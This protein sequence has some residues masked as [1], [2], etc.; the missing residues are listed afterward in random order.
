MTAKSDQPNVHGRLSNFANRKLLIALFCA[1]FSTFAQLYAPQAL[2]PQLTTAWGITF[3]QA[4]LVV[5]MGTIGL[6]IG[7]IPWV[8]VA[9]RIG[10]VRAM[11]AAVVVGTVC[12]LLTS[13]APGYEWVLALRFLTGLAVGAV[14]AL[15][16]AHLNTRLPP[17][18]AVKAAG[19][20]IAGNSLGGLVGRIMA[21]AIASTLG[22]QLGLLMAS[23][24]AAVAALG[25]LMLIPN[26]KTGMQRSQ[27]Q[28]QTQSQTRAE[29]PSK[30]R[31]A[32]PFLANLR[33]PAQLKIFTQGF[34]IM[35][36]F[37]TI[38]NYMGYRLQ[39]DPFYLPPIITTAVFAV[40]LFGTFASIYATALVTRFGRS[41]V[42][43][44]TGILVGVGIVVTLLPYLAAQVGGLVLATMGFFA[45]QAIASGWASSGM[46]VTGLE[47][48]GA[49][50]EPWELEDLEHSQVRQR[51]DA[52]R[53]PTAI[54]SPQSTDNFPRSQAGALYTL[55]YYTGGSVMGW[56][57]GE[58][59]EAFGWPG[60]VGLVALLAAT[61][62][63]LALTMGGDGDRSQS[64]EA[65]L[66]IGAVTASESSGYGSIRCTVRSPHQEKP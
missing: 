63:G 59:F 8:L 46:P 61:S 57:G 48:T 30:L 62:A 37:V 2:L 12:T 65:C 35:G 29:A 50:E 66:E 14:P 26:E 25:F 53:P 41:W 21:G 49:P 36:A 33:S 47:A 24:T 52:I 19:V 3:G 39:E 27:T 7:V 5:S 58:L 16:L 9:S 4:G 56:L 20:Y 10:T 55:A 28:P 40:Y 13:V 6:A 18:S 60:T 43:S 11:R 31:W 15:A 17:N 44:G 64:N 51:L 38:Y 1:G 45:G 23:G 34:L 42:L 54:S 22:W 32:Q